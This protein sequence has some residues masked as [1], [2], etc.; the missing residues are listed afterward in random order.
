M[1]SHNDLGK[2]GEKLAAKY[3]E[4]QGFEILDRNWRWN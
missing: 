3:L 1:A 2:E 4:A